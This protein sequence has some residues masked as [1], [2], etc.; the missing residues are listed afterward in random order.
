[1]PTGGVKPE[2]EN[3]RAWFDAGVSCVGLGSQLISAD[4]ISRGDYAALRDQVRKVI[5]IIAGLRNH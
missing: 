4:I 5:Q 2:E 3:L 1:M